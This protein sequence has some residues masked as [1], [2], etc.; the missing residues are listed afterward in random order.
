MSANVKLENLI[1]KRSN[2]TRGTTRAMKPEKIC[3]K[4]THS[5]TWKR[6]IEIKD[7]PKELNLAVRGRKYKP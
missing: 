6:K 2:C 3:L 7:T 1:I 5:F 4:T